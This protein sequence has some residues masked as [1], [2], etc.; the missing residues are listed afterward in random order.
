MI[1]ASISNRNDHFRMI[2]YCVICIVQRVTGN[3]GNS[4]KIKQAIVRSW[5]NKVAEKSF[6]AA[7]KYKYT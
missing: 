2:Q 5:R 6:G 4:K 7:K 3:T 1:C